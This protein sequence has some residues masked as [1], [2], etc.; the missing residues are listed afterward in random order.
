MLLLAGDVGGTKT[1]VAIVSSEAGPKAPLR[2][3]TYAS[4]DFARFEDLLR[5]FMAV[6]GEDVA[7]AC[8]A[9]A[10]PVVDDAV[11]ATNLPWWISGADLRQALGLERVWLINDMQAI[12]YALPTM[13]PEDRVALNDQPPVPGGAIAVMA[14]G[15]GLGEGYMTWDGKRYVA[16]PSEG[17]HTDFGPTDA[18]QIELLRHLLARF[19]HASYERVCAGSGLP[20][21]YAFFRDTGYAP[22]PDWLRE[23]LAAASD[24]TPII[25]QTALSGQPGSELCQATLNLVVDVYGAEAG[26]LALKVVPSGGLYIAGGIPPRILPLLTGG[27]F[28][29]RFTAKGRLGYLTERTPVYVLLNTQAGIIGAAAHGLERAVS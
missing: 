11:T 5:D 27:R 8:F 12:L 25:V 13:G 23:A 18:T 3:K 20:N 1:N 21:V 26:N 2:A 17:G 19:G 10:G 9:I 22:E 28:M 14:P 16:F 7:H 6:G 24:Q 29:Q 15:T 4:G